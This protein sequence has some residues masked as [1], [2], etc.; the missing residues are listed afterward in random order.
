MEDLVL[1]LTRGNPTEVKIV[2]ASVALALASYQLV[3]I[4]V[5][6]GRV[7]PPFL[8]ARPASFAHRASGDVILTLVVVVAIMCIS[9]FG[10]EAESAAGAVHV[11]AASAF[12]GLL[13][14]KVLL[15]RLHRGS[16][17]LPF[18]GS[19]VFVLLGV[20]WASSAGVMLAT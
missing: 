20:T 14:L 19:G 15:L 1:Q 6:Y 4:T 11:V 16:A 12:L 10:F 5:A 13:V 17:V 9:V 7:R 2:L 8:D 18:L 3:L